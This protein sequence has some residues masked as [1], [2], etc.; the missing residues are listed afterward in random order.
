MAT[1]ISQL[2]HSFQIFLSAFQSYPPPKQYTLLDLTSPFM[3]TA[4]LVTIFCF[5]TACVLLA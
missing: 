3:R 2:T 5:T 1:N 4:D